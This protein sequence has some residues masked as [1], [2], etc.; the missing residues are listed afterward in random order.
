M[1]LENNLTSI[2]EELTIFQFTTRMKLHNL[3]HLQEK[4]LGFS[5]GF[6]ENFLS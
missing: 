2:V 1:N 6:M 3:K 4:N 5:F